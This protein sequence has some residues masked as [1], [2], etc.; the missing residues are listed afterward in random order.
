MF[1][2][3]INSVKSAFTTKPFTPK[4]YQANPG[5]IVDA[6]ENSFKEMFGEAPNVDSLKTITPRQEYA[7][8][9]NV[10]A[11][12]AERTGVHLKL[13]Y[14]ELDE[15]VRYFAIRSA[16]IVWSLPET[17]SDE[18][19]R[20]VMGFAVPMNHMYYT[21]KHVSF[22]AGK[23]AAG[24]TAQLHGTKI[25]MKQRNRKI[26][27]DGEHGAEMKFLHIKQVVVSSGNVLT[28]QLDSDGTVVLFYSRGDKDLAMVNWHEERFAVKLT[29]V[30][31]NNNPKSFKWDED[32]FNAVFVKMVSQYAP[33]FTEELAQAALGA[34]PM[35]RSSVVKEFS[36]K[37]KAEKKE[38]KA[39]EK[40]E[41]KEAKEA[42]AEPAAA[43]EAA[44]AP[45]AE[46]APEVVK[47]AAAEPTVQAAP[48]NV[49]IDESPLPTADEALA[50]ATEAV[51]AVNPGHEAEVDAVAE[52]IR[53][54]AIGDGKV[55]SDTV[56]V[57]MGE[58]S[59]APARQVKPCR[60]TNAIRVVGKVISKKAKH[61]DAMPTETGIS[62]ISYVVETK[63]L[64][65]CSEKFSY[66]I[67]CDV[68]GT[69]KTTL[70]LYSEDLQAL[71]EAI[72]YDFG[73]FTKEYF[74]TSNLLI[75]KLLGNGGE[76]DP[77]VFGLK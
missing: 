59:A 28:A 39:A 23:F 64:Y 36:D 46:V 72:G 12:A 2:N 7:G 18:F 48:A 15:A 43:K 21:V 49:K 76:L 68:Q 17:I 5:K 35:T 75:T 52:Q 29:K 40:V 41:K 31:P 77:L 11:Y 58:L 22:D 65:V 67:L 4:A 66:S 56:T 16:M 47:E 60:D 26:R 63:M 24:V 37:N 9:E 69:A 6:L 10:F 33:R 71:G 42:T 27:T 20:V 57:D 8:G 62:T 54:A 50:N 25:A 45:T 51:K 3:A 32:E 74:I 14:E 1:A 19:S 70:T 53:E 13:L 55:E 34:K 73:R 38:T 30:E 61:L 44:P